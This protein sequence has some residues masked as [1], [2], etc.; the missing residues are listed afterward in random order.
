ML[1]GCAAKGDNP[2][3]EYAPQMYHSIPYE[4]LTQIKDKNHGKWL[5]TREDGLGEF[6]NANPN[7]PYEQNVRLP[8]AGTVRRTR[9]GVMPYRLGKDELEAAAAIPNPLPDTPEIL[10]EGKRLYELYCDHCH[11]AGGKGDGT[12]SQVVLGIPSYSSPTKRNLSEGHVFHVI[13][14]GKGLMG[15]HGSQIDPE[16]RWKIVKYVKKL[17]QD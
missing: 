8:V 7:N 13:T 1:A 10:K 15:A 12:V 11:G 3:L 17:Q 9:N 16:R 4:P 2:G 6:Y 5:S 14:H